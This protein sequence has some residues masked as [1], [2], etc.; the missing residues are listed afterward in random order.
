MS[1]PCSSSDEEFESA[2]EGEEEVN[3]DNSST[4][5]SEPILENTESSSGNLPKT[6]SIET[7]EAS[8]DEI[9]SAPLFETVHKLHEDERKEAHIPDVENLNEKVKDL[10]VTDSSLTN[11]PITAAEV[12]DEN[13]T[14]N[15]FCQNETQDTD[16]SLNLDSTIQK[17]A[18]TQD[19]IAA[20]NRNVRR[21]PSRTKPSLG[22][23]KLGAVKIPPANVSPACSEVPKGTNNES[24]SDVSSIGAS[25]DQVKYILCAEEFFKCFNIAT[26]EFI[27]SPT[28]KAQ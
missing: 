12:L 7:N 25:H 13:V 10:G 24:M 5:Q 3:V 16:N 20:E 17:R 21:V 14:E 11:K 26:L 6:A 28:T 8:K 1:I 27:P 19:L 2:D 4:S 9:L 18:E 22:A 15:K 23:K